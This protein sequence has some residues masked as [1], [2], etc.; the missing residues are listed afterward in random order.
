MKATISIRPSSKFY[1]KYEVVTPTRVIACHNLA[2]ARSTARAE[3]Q[4]KK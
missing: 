4:K 2:T 3:Q 1:G